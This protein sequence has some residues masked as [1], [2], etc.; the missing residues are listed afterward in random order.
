M[1]VGV[2]GVITPK[3]HVSFGGFIM[4]SQDSGK[5][6]FRVQSSEF[7]VLGWFLLSIWCGSLWAFSGGT[8]EPNDPYLIATAVDLLSSDP[9]NEKGQYFKLVADID[10]DPRLSGRSVLSGPLLLYQSSRKDDPGF[11]GV[12]DGDDHV[13]RNLTMV[14][15]EETTGLFGWVESNSLVENLHFEDVVIYGSYEE[16]GGLVAENAGTIRNC[17]IS[18]TVVFDFEDD[19]HNHGALVGHNSG[20]IEDCDAN[21]LVMGNL[22]SGLVGT[23]NGSVIDCAAQG[24]VW[25]DYAASGLVLDNDGVVR[26]CSSNGYIN[27]GRAAGLVE[28]NQGFIWT[29]SASGNIVGRQAGGLVV[30]NRGLIHSS[31]TTTNVVGNEVGSFVVENIGMISHCYASLALTP[32][33][34]VNQNTGSIDTCYLLALAGVSVNEESWSFQDQCWNCYVVGHVDDP[35]QWDPFPGVLIDPN[36]ANDPNCF[37]GFDFYGSEADGQRDLWFISN[38]G[39]PVLSWQ[40]QETGL[41]AIPAVTGLTV[42]EA[43]EILEAA[44]FVVRLRQGDYARTVTVDQSWENYASEN[45]TPYLKTLTY[46]DI[47]ECPY[48]LIREIYW[49]S[50]VV[51]GEQ[52]VNV[53]ALT[54]PSDVA[55]AGSLIDLFVTPGSYDF[56][57]NLG[58]GSLSNPYQIQTPGQLD[59]LAYQEDLWES[60]YILTTDLDMAGSPYA[61]AL[62]GNEEIPFVGSFDGG[63]HAIENLQLGHWPCEDDWDSEFG[64]GLFGIIDVNATVTRLHLNDCTVLARSDAY[65]AWAR[66]SHDGMDQVGALAG[67]NKGVVSACTATGIV[68]GVDQV[69]GLV[70]QNT[71]SISDCITDIQ[72]KG[73]DV[74]GGI[75]GMNTQVD[76]SS[77]DLYGAVLDC[78]A[79]G[80]VTGESDV[81]II[82]GLEG[83]RPS[84]G[85]GGR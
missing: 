9:V 21:C 77:T 8:G 25:G 33:Y 11:A 40:T 75:V 50:R 23:N 7:T 42:S 28:Y 46:L 6:R 10:L 16:G 84:H 57:T 22:V 68:Q 83:G 19:E 17:T 74:V 3:L 55:P 63:N 20:L 5:K 61:L 13:I 34:F 65:T 43:Q 18:G 44:G 4:R 30:I 82:F 41:V 54:R 51:V 72:V 62:L 71:G 52:D 69:G 38:Q 80:T 37:P 78:Q 66:Y 81:G 39:L 24:T 67:I 48:E 1:P 60:Y 58:N 26:H 2:Y 64:L 32:G 12:F 85:R 73:D 36:T 14:V 45:F 70:G 15:T 49:E 35:N 31:F 56:A 29:S 76:S 79:L 47:E 27:G 53:V 59:A